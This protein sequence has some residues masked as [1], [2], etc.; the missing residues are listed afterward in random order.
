MVNKMPTGVAVS[1]AMHHGGPFPSTTHPGFTAVGMPRSLLRF[2]AL[3][4]FDSVDERLLP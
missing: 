4:C 2:A 3:K 1:P